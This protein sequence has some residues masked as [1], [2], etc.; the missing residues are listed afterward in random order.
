M[1]DY[2]QPDFYRFNEDS[3]KL[4]NWIVMQSP[5]RGPLLDLGCG[6]GVIGIEIANRLA[7]M[8][9]TFLE[10]QSDFIEYLEKNIQEQM[11]VACQ[12]EIIHSS[13]GDWNP[14]RKYELIVCNPPYYLP[15]H[16]KKNYDS[17]RH[18]ARSFIIDNWLILLDKINCSL[19]DSGKAFLVIKNDMMISREITAIQTQLNV[20]FQE[21]G[22]LLFIELSRLDV[23]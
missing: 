8:D 9:L 4:V 3:L 21:Q 2:I 1:S 23:D 17:R 20:K 7:I 5:N 12:I 22:S 10:V 15:G 14:G 13:F 6:S 18:I 11:K 16:G 19:S